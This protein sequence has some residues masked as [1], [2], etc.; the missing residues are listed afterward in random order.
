MPDIVNA[1]L[2]GSQGILLGRR[3]PDRRAYP[4]RWS[5]PGGHVE[6]GEDL[7][8]A[9]ATR[10]PRGTRTHAPLVFLSHDDRDRK[11]GSFIPSLYRYHI[12]RSACHSRP[13]AHR[14]AMVHAAG[15]RGIG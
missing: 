10:N 5:F 6:A 9:T 4:N 14:A 7:D 2:P 12:G 8:C 3:S 11:T 1:V 13:G 15:S